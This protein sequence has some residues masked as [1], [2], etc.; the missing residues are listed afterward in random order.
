MI[1]S[2]LIA[3]VGWLVGYYLNLRAQRKAFLDQ[4]MNSARI[5][6]NEKLIDYQEWLINIKS[7]AS[8][9]WGVLYGAKDD[10]KETKVFWQTLSLKEAYGWRII[11]EEY[12]TLFPESREARLELWDRHE[13]ILSTLTAHASNPKNIIEEEYIDAQKSLINDLRI[14]LQNKS[15]SSITGN[16]ISEQPVSNEMFPCIRLVGN[17]LRIMQK[18]DSLEQ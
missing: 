8:R 10:K 6:I 17:Q 18:A 14:Y 2:V 12:E 9:V 15:L 4:I 11:L 7:A 3:V 16:T 5:A 13:N 1:T